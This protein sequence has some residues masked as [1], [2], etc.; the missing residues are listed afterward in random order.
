MI[1]G[2]KEKSKMPIYHLLS[3]RV[4]YYLH[5]QFWL[6]ML[7][8]KCKKYWQ[9]LTNQSGNVRWL[10]RGQQGPRHVVC[11]LC[12]VDGEVPPGQEF[13]VLNSGLMRHS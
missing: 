11:V 12:I 9:Y 10:T 7:T 4:H 2:G 3:H 13:K 6:W 8:V 1:S 5:W